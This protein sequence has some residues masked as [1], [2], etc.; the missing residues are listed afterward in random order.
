MAGM[1]TPEPKRFID[2]NSA[3]EIFFGCQTDST[4][5]KITDGELRI[6]KEYGAS[7]ASAVTLVNDCIEKML[8]FP[9]DAKSSDPGEGQDLVFEWI[10]AEIPE[11]NEINRHRMQ[12]YWLCLMTNQIDAHGFRRRS[13][14]LIPRN[15]WRPDGAY[16]WDSLIEQV[17]EWNHVQYSWIATS[18]YGDEVI[19]TKNSPLYE[20]IAIYIH[21]PDI[22]GPVNDIQAWIQN[23][24]Y[25][26][27]SYEEW[28][29]RVETYGDEH[30]I[31][32]G[33]IDN[34]LGV[35]ADEY[36]EIYR[37]LNPGLTW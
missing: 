14:N 29:D 21:G 35:K 31:G 33:G 37:K 34:D 15:E 24:I 23:I 20:G 12:S 2:L 16:F 19:L 25:L 9:F 4:G 30:S 7:S 26:G 18:C 13:L 27:S 11:I 8:A 36:R 28:M 10:E 3:L 1:K 5:I 17:P 32:P 22:S 6:E